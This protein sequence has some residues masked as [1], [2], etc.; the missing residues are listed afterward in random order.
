MLEMLVSVSN[1]VP[2]QY[3]TADAFLSDRH[4]GVTAIALNR[5]RYTSIR[6]LDIPLR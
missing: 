2:V 1:E 4:T 3:N 5:L 6:D